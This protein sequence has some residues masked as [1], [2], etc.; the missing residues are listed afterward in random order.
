MKM[1]ERR[2]L[3][4]GDEAVGRVLKRKRRNLNSRDKAT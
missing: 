2:D 1:R 4:I 3:R